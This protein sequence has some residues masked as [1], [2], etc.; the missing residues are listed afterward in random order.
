MQNFIPFISYVFIVTFTPGPNNIMSMVN[1]TKYG[2]KKTFNFMFGVFTG[3]FILLL[4]SSYSNLFL[5]NYI[6]KVEPFMKIIGGLYMLY[7]AYIIVK[8]THN[9]KKEL[10]KTNTFKAG[11]TLQL[12]NVKVILYCITIMGTFIIPN[13]ESKLVLIFFSFL[14]AFIGFISL[15]CWAF[16]GNFFNKLIKKY[17]KPF[18]IVM[19]SLLIYSAL[20]ISG[21]I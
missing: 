16:F 5:Y 15:N 13:Y 20:L 3:F 2:Y 9:H 12:V 10:V 19:A 21:V 8:P 4:V 7:L 17:E 14:L 11:L 6:P 1:A 18:N